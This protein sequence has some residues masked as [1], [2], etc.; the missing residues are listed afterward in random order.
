MLIYLS[1]LYL[2][3]SEGYIN[4]LSHYKPL[5]LAKNYQITTLPKVGAFLSSVLR[6]SLKSKYAYQYGLMHF[7]KFIA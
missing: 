5:S 2:I 4:I 7:Q 3:Q 1:Y 6:N